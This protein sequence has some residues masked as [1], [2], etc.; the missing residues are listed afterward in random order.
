[1]LKKAAAV[2]MMPAICFSGTSCAKKS[3]YRTSGKPYINDEHFNI[4][5]DSIK[6]DYEYE[7]NFTS[8]YYAVFIRTEFNDVFPQE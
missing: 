5:V 6:T 2:L 1:M 3:K 7:N 4:Y 8:Q